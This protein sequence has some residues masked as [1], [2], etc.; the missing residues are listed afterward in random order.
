MSGRYLNPSACRNDAT[1]D[2]KMRTG[3]MEEMEFRIKLQP[4]KPR[5]VIACQVLVAQ[6][7]VVR[8]W[9]G[10]YYPRLSFSSI[11]F[12]TAVWSECPTGIR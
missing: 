11:C 9:G 12:Q 5:R 6:E 2:G 1:L 4:G 8:A 3:L 7:R 10:P